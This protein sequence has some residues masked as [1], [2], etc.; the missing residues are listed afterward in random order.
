[1]LTK[2]SIDYKLNEGLQLRHMPVQEFAVAAILDGIRGASK[3]KLFEAFRGIKSLQ[4]ETAV[5]LWG[6]WTEIEQLCRD[7]EPLA[8][9]LSDGRKIHEWL[10]SRRA[11]RLYLIVVNCLKEGDAPDQQQTK[12][13]SQ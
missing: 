1:M 7:A 5:E 11:E 3:S 12:G 10:Q 13:D 2:Y 6:L 8:L 4:N 9:D